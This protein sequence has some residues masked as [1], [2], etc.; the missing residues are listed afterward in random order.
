MW[1][2]IVVLL[3]QIQLRNHIAAESVGWINIARFD[4]LIWVGEST[5]NAFCGSFRAF[6]P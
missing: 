5:F 3:V 4:M 2:K 6:E 1:S